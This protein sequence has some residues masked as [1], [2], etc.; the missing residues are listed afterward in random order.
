MHLVVGLQ[1]DKPFFISLIGDRC[2][3][4][5]IERW[6]R[7]VLIKAKIPINSNGNGPRLH[8]IRHSFSCHSFMK[9]VNDG[10]NLYCS[11]PY[12]STYLGHQSLRATEQYIRLTQQLHPEL[13]R[14]AEKLYIDILPNILDNTTHT[15]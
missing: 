14:D 10:M 5:N 13:I 15:L 3:N 4:G 6:F 8:D 1:P 9:L 7:R 2:S 12:L 11:W